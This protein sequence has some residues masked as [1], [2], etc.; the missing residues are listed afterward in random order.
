MGHFK[1]DKQDTDERSPIFIQWIDCVYQL[2][3]QFPNSFQ[4]N[5][6]LLTFLAHEVYTC[7]FGTF[8]FD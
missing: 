3:K 7:K 8:L 6:K 1:G 4:F 5:I 2:V